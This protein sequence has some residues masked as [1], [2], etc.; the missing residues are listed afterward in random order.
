MKRNTAKPKR[1]SV[2]ADAS[3]SLPE[4]KTLKIN[5]VKPKQKP[6]TEQKTSKINDVKPKRKPV[7]EQKTSKINGVMPKR[8]PVAA[9]VHANAEDHPAVENGTADNKRRK[10]APEAQ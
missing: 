9:D 3:S 6:V 10:R 4:Q 8:K 2:A 1:K 5:G 7:A